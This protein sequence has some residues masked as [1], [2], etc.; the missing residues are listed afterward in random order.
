VLNIIIQSPMFLW[1]SFFFFTGFF[2]EQS[3]KHFTRKI[4]LQNP[5]NMPMKHFLLSMLNTV[6]CRLRVL[7]KIEK[8]VYL[9]ISP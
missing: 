5:S 7:R 6:L 8:R 2:D 4:T 1:K 3:L 9:R